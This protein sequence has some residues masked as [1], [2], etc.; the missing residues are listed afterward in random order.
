ML[1]VGSSSSSAITQAADL[2]SRAFEIELSRVSAGTLV[3]DWAEEHNKKSALD[4]LSPA[5]LHP[6]FQPADSVWLN[7][8]AES[9]DYLGNEFMMW[10]WWYLDTQSDTISLADDSEVT[11]MFARTLS[12]ECPLGETGKESISSEMPTRLPEAMQAIRAGKLPRKAGLTLV[13]HN[14]Q[15]DLTLQA[16]TFGISVPRFRPMKLTDIMRCAPI[17][18]IRFATWADGGPAVQSVLRSTHWQEVD[19]RPGTTQSLVARRY[20][21]E[22]ETSRLVYIP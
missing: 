7:E 15:F 2:L 21:Q 14:Q 10:L 5:Q 16:E 3:N 1:Y 9:Y 17:V 8:F 4:D 11:A 6:D 19:Q 12:L 22:Q 20:E 18:S 13:R